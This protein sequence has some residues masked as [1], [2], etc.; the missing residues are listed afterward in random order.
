MARLPWGVLG[1]QQS[2]TGPFAAQAEAL[3]KRRTTSMIGAR[4]AQP[5][6]GGRGQEAD[7][8]GCDAHGQQ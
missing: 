4:M 3:E 5:G 2:R 6:H 8:E 7:E 1:G